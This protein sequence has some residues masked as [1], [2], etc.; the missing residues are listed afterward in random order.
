MTVLSR[1]R[2]ARRTLGRLT[3]VDW[4][5]INFKLALGLVFP[6]AYFLSDRVQASQQAFPVF[7]L[8]LAWLLFTG[9]GFIVSVAG[10]IMSA[11]YSSKIRSRGM[12]LELSGL[13][14]FLTGPV[15]YGI[16]LVIWFFNTWN[17]LLFAQ[18]ALAY[19]LSSAVLA[20]IYLVRRIAI[21]DEEGIK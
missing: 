18:V 15:L 17:P 12:R 11:Q 4:A 21:K 1:I 7:L 19:A 13:Y 8:T 10:L 9:L 3:R 6:L 20:R 2:C 5:Y 16:S 14:V